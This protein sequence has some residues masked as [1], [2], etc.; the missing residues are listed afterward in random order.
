MKSFAPVPS[1]N[2]RALRYWI[3]PCYCFY[4]TDLQWKNQHKKT[5]GN[6][7]VSSSDLEIGK[8]LF[9]FLV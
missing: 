2:L 3:L 4:G 7:L 8:I 9:A 6:D 5:S 1:D